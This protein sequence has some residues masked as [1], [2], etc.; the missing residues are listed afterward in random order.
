MS[1]L[2]AL[3][4]SAT[5]LSAQRL[6][7]NLISSNLANIN[8]TRTAEGGPYKRKDAV[9][10]ANPQSS[11]FNDALARQMD[12]QRIEVLVTEIR[13]DE[14]PP[15]LK[16]DPGHPDADGDGF[17]ALPNVNVVEEMVNMISASRS[18]EAN[19]TAIKATKDMAADAIDIGR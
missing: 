17:V 11:G 9:F 13:N 3:Q 1:L 16:F 14:R 2:D 5:G 19:V 4:T 15:V 6:R 8:T 10:T 7:M 18:Y 12:P